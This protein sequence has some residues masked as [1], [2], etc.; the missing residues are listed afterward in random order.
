MGADSDFARD[1][2]PSLPP[3][4]SS[5]GPSRVW[6]PHRDHPGVTV[7][8][9]LG[10]LHLQHASACLPHLEVVWFIRVRQYN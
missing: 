8:W 5:A 3:S 6:T 4:L 7:V 9:L 1:V 2:A 10:Q